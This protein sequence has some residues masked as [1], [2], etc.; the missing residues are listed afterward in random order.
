MPTLQM[1]GKA[2]YGAADT[3]NNAPASGAPDPKQTRQP[4]GEL[5]ASSPLRLMRQD[6][7]LRKTVKLYFERW[8]PGAEEKYPPLS[9]SRHDAAYPPITFPMPT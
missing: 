9:S 8:L 4:L 3:S 6:S 5:D 2:S 1:D 7:V